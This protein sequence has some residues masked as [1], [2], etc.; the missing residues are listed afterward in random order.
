MILLV[1]FQNKN[2]QPVAVWDPM[3]QYDPLKPND[4]GEYKLWKQRERVEKAT[5]RAAERK[6]V[7][8]MRDRGSDQTD[9]G[10]EEDRPRKSG[11]SLSA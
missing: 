9:S 4:Y 10:S 11:P 7:R 2:A 1:W 3:E 8:D 5:E 6:R